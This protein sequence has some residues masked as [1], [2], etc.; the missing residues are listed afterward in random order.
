[1]GET[2]SD[3]YFKDIRVTGFTNEYKH[4]KMITDCPERRR[5]GKKKTKPAGAAKWCSVYVTPR[6]SDEEC[7]EQGATRP[8]KSSNTGKALSACVNSAHCSFTSN[9]TESAMKKKEASNGES[10]EALMYSTAHK[11]RE[12]KPIAAGASLLIDTGASENMLDDRLIPGLKE[13]M[14]ESKELAKPKVVSVGGGHELDGNATGLIHC[15]VKDSNGEKKA[16]LLRGLVVPGLGRNVFSRAAQIKNGVKLVIEEGNPHLAVG[17]HTLPLKQDP[18]DMGMCSVDIEFQA[19]SEQTTASTK[20][21]SHALPD[22]RAIGKPDT[23]MLDDDLG[24]ACAATVNAN[25]WHRWLR[26]LNFRSMELLRKKE[27]NGVDFSDSMTPCDICAI[28]K[29]RQLAHPE[30]TN[31]ETTAPMQL[32]YTDNMGKTTPL[33]KG[34]FGYVSKFTDAYSWMKEI[35]LLK[36]ISETVR[37]LHAYNMQVAAPLGRRIEIIR[38][39]SGGENVANEFTKYFMDSDITIEYA[40]T[41]TPQQNGVSE[42]DGQTL[43][44]I[45]R[46]LMKDGAFPPTLWREQMM[47]AEYLSNRPPRST[48]GGVTPYFKMYNTARKRTCL[49]SSKAY[50]IYN[51]AT[52]NVVESRNVT[53]IETSVYS[54]PPSVLDD[55]NLYESDVLNFTSVLG[56]VSTREDEFD[57]SGTLD[58]VD[59]KIENQLLRQ[60]IRRM[61]HNNLIREEIQQQAIDTGHDTPPSPPTWPQPATG[62]VGTTPYLGGLLE[63]N[64]QV[65]T[66]HDVD[67][68]KTA[69]IS[70]L[71]RHV[72]GTE[73]NPEATL[74]DDEVTKGIDM[75]LTEIKTCATGKVIKG[76]PK[77]ELRCDWFEA[78]VNEKVEKEWLDVS[79]RAFVSDLYEINIA[80]WEPTGSG[81]NVQLYS[82]ASARSLFDKAQKMDDVGGCWIHLL[83]S[84]LGDPWAAPSGV[85]GVVDENAHDRH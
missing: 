18:L 32:V 75:G 72:L 41:N 21:T 66:P 20:P 52:G 84:N 39:E 11:G 13:I 77:G 43:T 23:V 7:F 63:C 51:P 69:L 29:S 54:M 46:Y 34:G 55:D 6:Y 85:N 16:V 42:R 36:A 70:R 82:A 17:G 67:A 12:F 15:T 73:F 22:D 81:E 50:R 35:Y 2:I 79:W 8:K 49:A 14:R 60:E 5:K 10:E 38:C 9:K 24:V 68:I 78:R 45:T 40:A 37:A 65:N 80:V 27:D 57:G 62:R 83:F 30:K 4:V 53:F 76:K 74:S 64:G 19:A 59:L 33:A 31:R 44:T 48:L 58:T 1:M 26:H 71:L 25:T 28:S 47:T 3:R 56:K 61:R